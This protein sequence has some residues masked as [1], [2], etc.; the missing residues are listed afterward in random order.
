[1]QSDCIYLVL[2]KTRTVLG[3]QAFRML[4]LD[5]RL[6]P[7]IYFSAY[8]VFFSTQQLPFQTAYRP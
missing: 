1:M 7:N 5:V 3:K 4:N 2:I 6:S 8:V